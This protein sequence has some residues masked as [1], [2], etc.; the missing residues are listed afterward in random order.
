MLKSSNGNAVYV[1]LVGTFVVINFVVP[2][3]IVMDTNC[4]IA[5]YVNQLRLAFRS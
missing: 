2:G 3:K 4:Y 5:L 1:L